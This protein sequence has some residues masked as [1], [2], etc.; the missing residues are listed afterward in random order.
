MSECK[1]IGHR[2]TFSYEMHCR[3]CG[4]KVY[5]NKRLAVIGLSII[6]ITTIL[7]YKSLG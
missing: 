6:A 4:K 3:R 5:E 7:G 2:L 1:N